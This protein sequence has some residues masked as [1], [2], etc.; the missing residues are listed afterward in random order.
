[1][2]LR[3]VLRSITKMYLIFLQNLAALEFFLF[4]FSG[5]DDLRPRRG[6]F[7]WISKLINSR[8]LVFQKS[9]GIRFIS[10]S[11]F[12]PN[13]VLE[14]NGSIIQLLEILIIIDLNI[15]S[16][17]RLTGFIGISFNEGEAE[18]ERVG[19]INIL[20]SI[21]VKSGNKETSVVD[22]FQLYL[23]DNFCNYIKFYI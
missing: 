8:F 6:E 10:D 18:R 9:E 19:L 1:M 3:R 13:D 12:N 23:V 20:E 5:I 22:Q 7:A 17:S 2:S 16:P 15:I 11:R 14:L 21:G 4:S